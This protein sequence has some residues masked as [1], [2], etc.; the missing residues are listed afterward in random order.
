[1]NANFSQADLTGA[2]L[3]QASFSL[4]NFQQAD[5]R[6]GDLRQADLMKS[7]LSRA[8][9]R[10]AKLNEA[11]LRESH[12]QETNLSKANINEADFQW[13]NL[14]RADLSNVQALGTNFMAA[15]FTGTCVENW[16]I[17]NRTQ[18]GS[19]SCRY[20]YVENGQSGRYPKTGNFPLGEFAKLLT[21][22][23][24]AAI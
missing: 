13:A 16:L 7:D 20:V 17:D 6:W 21:N 19:T 12:L 11:N 8:N 3:Y 15:S 1:M 10:G 23:R 9:L 14:N 18:F 2:Y 22:T 5:L 24:V 4:A